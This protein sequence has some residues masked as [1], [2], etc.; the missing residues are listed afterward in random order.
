MI[1]PVRR[2][3]QALKETLGFRQLRDRKKLWFIKVKTKELDALWEQGTGNFPAGT[4]NRKSL[5]RQEQGF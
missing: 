1:S 3:V 4:G 2:V 5:F